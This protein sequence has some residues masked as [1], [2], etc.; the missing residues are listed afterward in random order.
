MEAKNSGDVRIGNR[1]RMVN[2]LFTEGEMT[3]QEL[4]GRLGISLATVNYLVKELTER[5]LL[6]TGEVRESTGGRKPVG[7]CPVYGARYS[8]G[9]EAA[10]DMLYLALVDLGGHVASKKSVARKQENTRAYWQAVGEEIR[11]FQDFTGV[12]REKLLDVGITLGVTMQDEELAQR[13]GAVSEAAVDLEMA[14]NALGMTAHFRNSAKMAAVAHC[15]QGVREGSF[16]Y[17]NLG[18]KL[19]AA[20]IHEGNVLDFAGINGEIGCMMALGASKPQYLDEMFSVEAIC[21]RTGSGSIGEFFDR[22]R[23]KDASCCAFWKEYL[24]EFSI[25]LHN[26]HCMFG[27]RIVLGGPLCTCLAAELPRLEAQMKELYPFVKRPGQ[28]LS[29]SAL[30]EY[31]AAVGAAMLPVDKYLEFV[32]HIELS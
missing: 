26:L 8:V 19:S 3:K 32:P 5:G 18:Q 15:W 23:G 6:T 1:K 27:W 10:S 4:V 22:L 21:G 17:V 9:V 12:P 13:R 24:R 16:V 20:I 7:I 2:L 14:R 25:F 31:G 28:I 30:G 29:V 11:S